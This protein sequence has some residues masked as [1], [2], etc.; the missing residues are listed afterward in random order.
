MAHN[1]KLK[2][3]TVHTVI[4]LITFAFCY[5]LFPSVLQNVAFDFIIRNGWYTIPWMLIIVGVMS[6]ARNH[7]DLM[8]TNVREHRRPLAVLVTLVVLATIFT[9]GVFA[10][11]DY[12]TYQTEAHKSNVRAGLVA[13]APDAIRFTPRANACTEI[14]NS[15][16]A[17]GEH[18]VCDFV[19]PMVTS[20]GFSYAAPITPSG[21]VNTYMAKNPGF[22][23]L[24]DSA[25]AEAHPAKRLVRI[26]EKQTV[27][28]GMHWF[29]DLNYVLAHTDFFATYDTPH[30]LA[31][32]PKQPDMFTLVVP[33]IKY[34]YF[35]FPYWGGDV[36]IH[37]DGRVE[38]LTAE[39]AMK[40][41]RLKGK[42]IYPVS[43]ARKYVELQNYAAGHGILTPWL[44]LSGKF[45]VESVEGTDNEFPF[46]TQG[47]DGKLYLVTATKGEGSAKGL[48]RMYYT[49]AST[50][51]STYHQ[52][53]PHEVIY[54]V[55]ASH[56][57]ITNIPGYQWKHGDTGIME[58]I[59]P[60]YI[61]RPH[62]SRLY[63]KFTI[64]NAGRAGIA[65]TAVINASQPDD[66]KVFQHRSDFDAWMTGAET[67]KNET[68][69]VSGS[70]KLRI[71]AAI[72]GIEEQLKTLRTEADS[73]PQD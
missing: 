35:R 48:F 51:A 2:A 25:D 61:V 46:L 26:D 31:L 8:N 17:T 19:Q 56:T 65:A 63:W 24:D 9:F 73:L 29:D 5:W 27:G 69:P 42:W 70:L 55:T 33:K 7:P 44:R 58:A 18:V 71:L 40:D 20:R 30:F 37:A 67:K 57:R 13:S 6:Y 49:D 10:G 64:T 12:F 53:G 50:G 62:D 45:E 43:L 1:S 22:F 21:L 60:V 28:Q 72:S 41:P 32:D 15:V 23:V 68:Q 3:A 54:G 47:V 4:A 59:E 16:S 34:R 11:S 66:L 14:G 39:M 38:D 36:L 52:F